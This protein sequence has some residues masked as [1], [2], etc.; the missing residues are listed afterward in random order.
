MVKQ[1]V[2]DGKMFCSSVY[3]K[4]FEVRLKD[5]KNILYNNYKRTLNQVVLKGS[6]HCF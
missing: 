5:F 3:I 2:S 4:F 6:V 1:E